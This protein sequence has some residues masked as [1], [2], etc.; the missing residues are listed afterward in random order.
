MEKRYW[1]E[2]SEYLTTDGLAVYE[3]FPNKEE[4]GDYMR[5]SF[6]LA[7]PVEGDEGFEADEIP[8]NFVRISPE[9]WQMIQDEDDEQNARMLEALFEDDSDTLPDPVDALVSFFEEN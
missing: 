4:D 8:S 2:Q 1:I 6:L 3:A 7:G 9:E 5:D